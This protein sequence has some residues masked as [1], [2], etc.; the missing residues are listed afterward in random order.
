MLYGRVGRGVD[1]IRFT[2]FGPDVE[3]GAAS[4]AGA[5]FRVQS[6]LGQY[7]GLALVA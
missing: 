1:A 2:L 5:I 7:R 4:A 3:P 6:A